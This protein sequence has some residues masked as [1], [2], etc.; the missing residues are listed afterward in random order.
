MGKLHEYNGTIV[1]FLWF[2]QIP[3]ERNIILDSKFYEYSVLERQNF[4]LQEDL[5]QLNQTSKDQRHLQL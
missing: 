3:S 4:L 5:L 1:I 2:I